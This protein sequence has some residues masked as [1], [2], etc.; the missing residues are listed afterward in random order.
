MRIAKGP[1]IVLVVRRLGRSRAS[2]SRWR[3]AAM[4]SASVIGSFPL[5][6]VSLTALGRFCGGHPISGKPTWWFASAHD[7]TSGLHCRRRDRSESA[8]RWRRLADPDSGSVPIW[9]IVESG[10]TIAWIAGVRTSAAAPQ[11][12][13]T[14]VTVRARR[15]S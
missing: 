1:W 12:Q 7:R 15:N 14:M 2:R 6:R 10:G 13:P 8:Q 11:S 3:S 4:K 5:A 9:P